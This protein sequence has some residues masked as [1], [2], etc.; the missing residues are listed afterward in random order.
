MR[1]SSP[2]NVAPAAGG[3]GQISSAENGL[4]PLKVTPSSLY[5]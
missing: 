3:R 4:G 5:G 1:E 2:P